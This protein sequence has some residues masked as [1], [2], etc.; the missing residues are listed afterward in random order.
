VRAVRAWLR[1]HVRAVAACFALLVVVLAAVVASAW[2]FSSFVLVPDHSP[3]SD[4]VEIES[5]SPTR[6]ELRRSEASERPGYYGL[7]WDGGH[8][9]VGPVLEQGADTVIRKLSDARG[10]LMPGTEA[11]LESNVYSGNPRE[12][13]GLPYETVEV[14][15]QL[16]PMPAWLIPASG[17]SWAVIVHGINDDREIGHRLSPALHRA[18]LRTMVIS[19]RDDLGAPSSPDGFHHQGQTEWRDL[20]AAVRYA[21]AHGAERVVLI[22]YS[23][24]GA[25]ITQ[26]MQRSDLAPEVAALVLDAPALDWQEIL[27]FNATQMGFPAFTAI[28]VELAVEARTDVDWES[29]D[30]VQH[31][32]AFQLPILLFHSE[33]DEVVPIETSEEFAEALPRWVTYYRVPTAG[34][35]QSW[36]VDPRLYERRLDAFLDEALEAERARSG[37]SGSK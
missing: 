28:P 37:G 20:A 2:H 32:E 18:G 22:G 33:D 19:Y 31:L 21:L 27:S 24:G 6:I 35:T 29:L 1:R 15:G 9:V 25:L 11:G 7:T 23:M 4:R 36:N 5:V 10:Y 3:W 12:A 16:G 13:R 8:A 34:H 26:F 30:A 14:R 17:D